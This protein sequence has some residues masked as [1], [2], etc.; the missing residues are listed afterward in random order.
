MFNS[1]SD[2]ELQEVAE[3]LSRI[4]K[5]FDISLLFDTSKKIKLALVMKQFMT[6]HCH[7][8]HCVFSVK[9]GKD[10]TCCCGNVRLPN[11]VFNS[12]YHLPDPIPSSEDKNRYIEAL[13]IR[14]DKNK[15]EDLVHIVHLKT[16]KKLLIM[17]CLSHR[18]HKPQRQPSW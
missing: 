17:E 4:D 13:L 11:D 3:M 9:K 6:K 1:P 10:E 8:R 2:E 15:L 16:L 12:V 5:D 14:T 7:D 18:R